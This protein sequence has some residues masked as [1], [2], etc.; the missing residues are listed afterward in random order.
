MIDNRQKLLLKAM[1][2]D[3]KYTRL[4]SSMPISKPVKDTVRGLLE[5]TGLTTEQIVLGILSKTKD[6][7]NYIDEITT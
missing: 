6:L 2:N 5:R 1:I 3:Y 4:K 7:D